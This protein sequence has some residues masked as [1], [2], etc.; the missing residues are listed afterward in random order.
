MRIFASGPRVFGIRA[1]ISFGP[2]DERAVAP[3]SRLFLPFWT[4]VGFFAVWIALAAWG[5]FS[6]EPGLYLL[7]GQIVWAILAV[8][9]VGLP[10][11]VLTIV[12]AILRVGQ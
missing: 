11:L 1:G 4:N 5:I 7:N 3:P 8:A 2:E 9:F 6:M 12:C 10:W